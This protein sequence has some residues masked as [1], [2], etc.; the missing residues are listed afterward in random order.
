M[1]VDARGRL[2]TDGDKARANVRA[3][4]VNLDDGACG[5]APVA[6]HAT[7]KRG[8]SGCQKAY[9]HHDEI[10]CHVLLFSPG[11]GYQFHYWAIVCASRVFPDQIKRRWRVDALIELEV[12]HPEF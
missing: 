6:E 12:Q 8:G 5:I 3:A 11:P 7:F 9:K 2:A 4:V 10:F 1:R